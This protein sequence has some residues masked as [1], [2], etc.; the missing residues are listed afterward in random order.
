MARTAITDIITEE[1]DPETLEV[2]KTV[3]SI[4]LNMQSAI[5]NFYENLYKPTNLAMMTLTTS[6]IF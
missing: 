6:K 2:T 5:H 3:H 4:Q 1:T